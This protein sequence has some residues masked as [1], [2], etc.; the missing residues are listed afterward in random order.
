M[1]KEDILKHIGE[2]FNEVL[3]MKSNKQEL[4]LRMIKLVGDYDN[5]RIDFDT[6]LEKVHLSII[7]YRD[8]KEIK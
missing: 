6:Y 3:R 5:M 1:D 2:K 4:G 7:Q 8:H